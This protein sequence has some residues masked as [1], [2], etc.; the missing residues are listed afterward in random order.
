MWSVYR[1]SLSGGA[2]AYCD[3]LE[4]LRHAGFRRA[5]AREPLEGAATFPAAVVTDARRDPADVTRII[6]AMLQEAGLR[7]VSVS[8]CRVA[9]R[10]PAVR[11][12]RA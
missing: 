3:A 6:F 11:G 4:I 9:E 12:A 8:G 2:R 7:P 1:F 5:A 10:P